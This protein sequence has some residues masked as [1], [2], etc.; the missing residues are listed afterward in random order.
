MEK[1]QNVLNFYWKKGNLDIA[2]LCRT[3]LSWEL[4]VQ[5][6]KLTPWRVCFVTCFFKN[7]RYNAT[8][9]V[10]G[11]GAL[12]LINFGSTEDGLQ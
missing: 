7:K 1:I 9:T 6:A 10:V 11:A 8:D 2:Q 3:A 4:S 5:C 12:W